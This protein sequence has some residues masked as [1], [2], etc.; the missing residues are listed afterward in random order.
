VSDLRYFGTNQNLIQKGIKRRLNSRN[1]CCHSVQI[2]LYSRL[3]SRNVRIIVYNAII[4]P[5]VLY[6]YETLYLASSEEHKLR[7]FKDRLLR[8]IFGP[9]RDEEKL[10]E[11]CLLG[12]YAVWLL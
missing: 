9:K 10:E 4:L 7:L 3:L 1:V 6:G 2:L 5:V 12:C 8:R 11:W